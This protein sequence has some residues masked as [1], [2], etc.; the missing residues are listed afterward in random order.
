MGD[1]PGRNCSTTYA[2]GDGDYTQVLWNSFPSSLALNQLFSNG[3]SSP[4]CEYPG[5]ASYLIT[6]GTS[7]ILV[8]FLTDVVHE[9]GFDGVY[10]DGYMRSYNFS[11]LFTAGMS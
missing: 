6:N 2:C 10:M 5:Q 7:E 3:S 8:K 1:K 4:L 11:K 9:A